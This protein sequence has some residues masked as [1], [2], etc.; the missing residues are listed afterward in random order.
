MNADNSVDFEEMK[1]ESKLHNNT[2]PLPKHLKSLNLC[3][4]F[5]LKPDTI[6]QSVT[7]LYIDKRNEKFDFPLSELLPSSLYN[8]S[9]VINDT[10]KAG[11]FSETLVKLNLGGCPTNMKILV[12]MLPKTLRS[13]SLPKVSAADVYIEPGALPEGLEELIFGQR[14]KYSA[15][16]IIPT[17]VTTLFLPQFKDSCYLVDILPKSLKALYLSY[18]SESLDPC[19]LPPTVEVLDMPLFNSNFFKPI[20]CALKKLTLYSFNQTI[21]IGVLPETLLELVM[22]HYN[23][24]MIRGLLPKSLK[25]L[26]TNSLNHPLKPGDLNDG[27]EV[28]WLGTYTSP[29]EPQSLPTSLKVFT[30]SNHEYN[31]PL[32][33]SYLINL[34][35][36][37][38]D[39]VDQE[40]PFGNETLPKSLRSLYIGKV[41]IETISPKTLNQGLLKLVLLEGNI[42]LK[43]T[44]LFPQSLQDLILPSNFDSEIN[45]DD[46]PPNLHTLEFG[47]EFNTK[48]NHLPLSLRALKFRALFNCP[49]SIALPKNLRYIFINNVK[50]IQQLPKFCSVYNALRFSSA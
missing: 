47:R 37:H 18:Y 10:F 21:D 22:G 29:F 28:L 14:Y 15:L 50:L 13:I 35:E 1:I 24:P 36:L 40:N 32:Q 48:I 5:P 3:Y 26:H 30:L 27:L 41:S 16:N 11:D 12:G 31:H 25:F 19:I 6:P 34:Q 49:I 43:Q 7:S 17:S 33:I 4:N 38:L 44:N 42:N 2:Y 9:I 8:L 39:C 46:L 45:Q 23:K 20:T